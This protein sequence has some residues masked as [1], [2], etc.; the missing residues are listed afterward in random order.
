MEYKKLQDNIMSIY[1]NT[2]IE[3]LN[4][5]T[6]NYRLD[7]LQNKLIEHTHNTIIE[8]N[9]TDKMNILEKENEYIYK[10]PWCKLSQVHKII[11]I[12]EYIKTQLGITNKDDEQELISICTKYIKNKKL[13]KKNCVNYDM[14]K[15]KI[16]SIPNLQYDGTKYN[17]NI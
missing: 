14:Y 4:K 5:K 10:K 17:L 6:L 13:T 8:H 16:I 1:I 3:Q 15:T 7:E 9:I 11:K 2:L 12:K